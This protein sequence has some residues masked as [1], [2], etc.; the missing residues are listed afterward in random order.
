[1]KEIKRLQRKLKR[2]RPSLARQVG[3]ARL[4]RRREMPES[5]GHYRK[6]EQVQRLEECYSDLTNIINILER[7]VNCEK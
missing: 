6:V 1:M 3:R 2:Q 5:S 7:C 4:D